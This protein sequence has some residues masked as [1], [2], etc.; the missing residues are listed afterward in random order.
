MTERQEAQRREVRVVWAEEDL[1]KAA[2][3]AA[4]NPYS[5]RALANLR[6]AQD[7]LRDIKEWSGE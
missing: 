2:K 6:R 7:A 4:R 1:K 3:D 5:P